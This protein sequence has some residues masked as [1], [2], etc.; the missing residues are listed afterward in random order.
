MKN[1]FENRVGKYLLYAA[2][3]ILLVVI[4]ILIALQI[5]NANQAR[6]EKKALEGHLKTISRNIA[7]DLKRIRQINEKRKSLIAGSAYLNN[8]I[9]PRVK[10]ASWFLRGDNSLDYSKEDVVFASKLVM[11][12]WDLDYLNANMSGFESLKNSGY[13]SKLQGEALDSLISDYY[14]LVKEVSQTENDYNRNVLNAQDI[15]GETDFEGAAPFFN[16]D[17]LDYDRTINDFREDFLNIVES[18]AV[19]TTFFIPNEITIDYDNLAIIGEKIVYL[20]NS[21]DIISDTSRIMRQSI[22]DK[23][24]D[25]GYPKLMDKGLTSGQYSLSF[26]S[27]HPYNVGITDINRE[28]DNKI[29]FEAQPWG[30]VYFYVG[31]SSIELLETKD[32]SVYKTLKLELRGE[33]GGE[34]VMIGMKDETNPTDGSETKITLELTKEWETYEIPLTAFVNTNLKKIFMP[35]SFVFE[36]EAANIYYRHIEYMY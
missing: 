27:S 13:L 9:I 7:G 14:T 23:Y 21:K 32:F 18:G 12:A 29:E 8:N 25:I 5:N 31:R 28:L 3:E 19:R 26:A 1:L 2:G 16:P 35:I 34:K 22:F 6:V 4:G 33:K 15:V 36:N 24:G 20:I 10:K 30:V 11:S 17:D